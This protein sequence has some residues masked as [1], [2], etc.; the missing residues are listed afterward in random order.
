[1]LTGT[2]NTTHAKKGS[3]MCLHFAGKGYGM[4]GMRGGPNPPAGS[5]INFSNNNLNI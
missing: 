2:N 1:M 5:I 3:N 4:V